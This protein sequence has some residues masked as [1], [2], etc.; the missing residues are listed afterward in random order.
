M[1][2]YSGIWGH[3]CNKSVGMGT[4]YT[5]HV[6]CGKGM[7]TVID[8]VVMVVIDQ[9]TVYH[10]GGNNVATSLKP[11]QLITT[12]GLWCHM[13]IQTGYAEKLFLCVIASRI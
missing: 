6:D 11:Q 13:E 3:I 4:Q 7:G 1:T 10:S 5:S 9:M 2:W 12:F 8:G